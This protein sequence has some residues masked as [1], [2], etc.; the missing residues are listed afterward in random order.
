[1]T[2]PH[3]D[4]LLVQICRKL[5][6]VCVRLAGK[7]LVV[8]GV[9]VLDVEHHEVGQRH[10]AVHFLHKDR[11]VRIEGDAGGVNTGMNVLRLGKREELNQKINL[12]EGFS[13]G[14]GQAAAVGVERAVSFVLLN[15]IGG[16]HHGASCHGPGVRIVT[17]STSHGASLYEHN[18][19]RAGSVN[20]AEALQRMNSSLHFY[21]FLSEKIESPVWDFSFYSIS[22]KCRK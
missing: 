1:M 9:D 2:D 10:Q 22:E 18:K 3:I 17:I 12:H 4:M 20:G 7:L 13:A 8:F 11:A 5:Q 6:D 21:H 16:F 14:D 15:N 19:T